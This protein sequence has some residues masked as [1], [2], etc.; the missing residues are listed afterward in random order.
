MTGSGMGCPDWPK[1]FGYYIPPTEESQL[2]WEPDHNYFKGQV[3][4]V[5]KSLK[6][7]KEAFKSNSSFNLSHWDTYEK[8]DYAEFNAAHTWIE[9]I[10]RLLGALSG[11]AILIMTISSFGQWKKNKKL[12]LFSILCLVF[13][14]FQAWLGATVVYSVLSP[15]RITIHMLVALVLVALLIYILK[16]SSN[17][18]TSL[19]STFTYRNLL[20]FA[21]I[22]SL[23][24]VGMGTQVRQFVDEQVDLV[25]YSNKSAW[26]DNPTLVFFAHR[27]FSIVVLLINLGIWWLNKTRNLGFKLT[28]WMMLILFV[29][30]LSGISM[31]YLD[32]P[33]LTQPLHLVFAA[34]LFGIQF[35][36]LMQSFEAKL[37]TKTQ[38]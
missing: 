25:G 13:L 1:C 29:E 4:I 2:K 10:N 6:V 26:L 18:D 12:T 33:F 15:V 7:A 11:I 30:I 37:I 38:T 3:I 5:G 8:H 23:I 21:V 34:L 22:L 16:L 31:F 35:Y 14:L 17:E 36:I 27:S 19:K 32:F 24:Q 28:N 9:Y 20:V